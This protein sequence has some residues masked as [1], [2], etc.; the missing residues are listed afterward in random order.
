[1][2]SALE[3]ERLLADEYVAGLEQV[4]MDELRAKRRECGEVESALSYLRRL[5][6]GRLDLLLA[7]L[8]RREEGREWSLSQLIEELK[9]IFQE[10]G[11]RTATGRLPDLD[12]PEVNE[13]LLT[14]DL[15][16]TFD[17]SKLGELPDLP[18]AEVRS[19]ADALADLE[20]TVSSQRRA[21]HERLDLLQAEMVRRYKSGDATV[22][23]LL[24]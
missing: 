16:K 24:A 11:T 22:D 7:E 19:L 20:R 2:A 13:R 14:A 10:G 6:Q 18:D 21:L 1:M 9:E 5:V 8:Q 23:T 17:I 4:P 15:D 12:L 3:L